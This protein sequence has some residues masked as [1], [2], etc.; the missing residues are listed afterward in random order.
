[1]IILYVPSNNELSNYT[2]E[3]VKNITGFVAKQLAGSLK[4]ELCVCNLFV[5][6]SNFRYN[7]KYFKDNIYLAT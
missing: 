1:M 2:K 4:C 3:I 6:K 5:E 7:F